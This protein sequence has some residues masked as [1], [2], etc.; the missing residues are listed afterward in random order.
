M[1]IGSALLRSLSSLVACA[2]LAGGLCPAQAA[3]LYPQPF[4]EVGDAAIG[5]AA[6]DMNGDGLPDL[7][8]GARRSYDGCAEVLLGG[9]PALLRSAGCLPVGGDPITF[10]VADFD[11]DGRTD[12]V[13]GWWNSVFP[14]SGGVIVELGIGDGTFREAGRFATDSSP[15]DLAA[16]DFNGDSLPD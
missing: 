15:G 3:P 1:R 8:A 10:A 2:A 9:T 12:V 14:P 4:F 11:R 13:I 7:V 6:G 16:G 5:V